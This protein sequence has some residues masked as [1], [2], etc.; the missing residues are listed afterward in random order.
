MRNLFRTATLLI[1]IGFSVAAGAADITTQGS[2]IIS[3]GNA[4]SWA[5]PFIKLD[6]A[7]NM[8]YT[9]KGVIVGVFDTGLDASSYKFAGNIAG[10]GYDV[11][12]AKSVTNDPNWHGTFV[13]SIIAANTT[14]GTTVGMYGVASSAKIL[15]I[16]VMDS[17]GKGS[18]TDIQ[19]ANGINYAIANGAK[20]FNNSW[21]SN[22]TLA[23][24]G[25]YRN[26]LLGWYPKQIAAYETASS[27]GII[28][29]WAAG[30]SGLK[31]PGYYAT[32]PAVD[33]KLSGSWIVAVAVDGTGKI[34]SYSN[35]CGIAASYCLAAPGS[36]IVGVYQKGV[37][38]ASGTSFAAPIISGAAAVLLQEWPYLS[39]AQITSILFNSANKTGVY[40]DKATYGQGMLDLAAATK[41]QGALAVPTAA[42]VT[43]GSTASLAQSVVVLPAA[44]GSINLPVQQMA[45]VDSFNRA[46]MIDVGNM[47]TR[48]PNTLDLQQVMEKFDSDAIIT[49]TAGIKLSLS[50]DA[51]D[52]KI[53]QQP[54]PL[55]GIGNP[56]LNMG[57]GHKMAASGFGVTT[58]SGQGNETLMGTPSYSGA[59]Y[60]VGP[61]QVGL[62]HEDKSVLGTPSL[63]GYGL[64][65]GADSA[66]AAFSK[67]WNLMNGF[68]LDT[69][70]SVGY[71][72]LQGTAGM[73]VKTDSITTAAFGV[74]V[75][76]AN[77]FT[78]ADRLGFAWSIPN[79]SIGGTA[80]MTVPASVDA[81]GNIGYQPVKLN[82]AS[83]T[84]E[85]DLQAYWTTEVSK[86]ARFSIA[87]GV[88]LQPDGI[89]KTSAQ[90]IGMARFSLRF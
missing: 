34:A 64:A 20:V 77:V 28:N 44:V 8:G 80:R 66:F 35:R 85:Q 15:P 22:L 89:T 47:V 73:S 7:R 40:A 43:Q 42:N 2:Y 79:H 31:D 70:A 49:D 27:K 55:G 45:V 69:M 39:G 58:W 4:I 90:G 57:Q 53:K 25:A 56:W 86:Q 82:L 5:Y 59:M 71:T 84:P 38:V 78:D 74:G 67:R 52:V 23:D 3:G 21:N 10:P 61:L 37:A 30:N 14:V 72:R 83:K 87:A 50:M 17:T 65:Q 68:D 62:L 11:Y 63:G 76:W 46:Y 9:G 19:L 33:S 48:A 60:N 41:P 29:V 88:R 36:D 18:F 24:L 26:S 75:S 81:D 12:T 54:L 16:R 32:L 1:S 6:A 13:S 51:N